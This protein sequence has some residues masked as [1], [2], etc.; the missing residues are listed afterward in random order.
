[1]SSIDEIMGVDIK[2]KGQFESHVK[3]RLP[4]VSLHRTYTDKG[5]QYG[6]ET[7]QAMYELYCHGRMDELQDRLKKH[8]VY[9]GKS[10][11]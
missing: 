8:D 10:Q 11:Y 7:V 2:H 4:S 1:M 9:T 5:W 6:A 3:F